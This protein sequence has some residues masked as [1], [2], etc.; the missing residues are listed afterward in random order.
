MPVKFRSC[1]APR[2]SQSLSF[3]SEA[4]RRDHGRAE[5]QRHL[6]GG[7]PSSARRAEDQHRLAGLQAPAILKS[8]QGR[9]VGDWDRGGGFI[10][11]AIRQRDHRSGRRNHFL[12]AAI[13]ADVCQHALANTEA[14]NARPDG[15]NRARNLAAGRERQLRPVLVLAVQHER[16]EKVERN[17][18]YADRHLALAGGRGGQIADLQ[19]VWAIER[20]A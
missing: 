7:E 6:H 3:S 17:G 5:P 2:S 4:A 15:G 20:L 16:V 8:V 14:L 19:R 1:C 9:T 12:A 13:I 10:G 18:R 11:N